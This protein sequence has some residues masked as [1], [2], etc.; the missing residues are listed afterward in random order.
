[1]LTFDIIIYIL[2]PILFICGF[3]LKLKFKLSWSYILFFSIMLVYIAFVSGYTLFPVMWDYDIGCLS[4]AGA[5]NVLQNI[6]INPFEVLDFLPRQIY[7]NVLL[8]IPF[9]FGVNFLTKANLNRTMIYGLG[10]TLCI[11]TTQ[12]LISLLLGFS[13]RV[14]DVVDVI[15]NLTGV[16]CGYMLFRAFCAVF[17]KL[18]DHFHLKGQMTEYIAGCCRVTESE[19]GSA[20]VVNGMYVSIYGIVIVITIVFLYISGGFVTFSDDWIIEINEIDEDYF[21]EITN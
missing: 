20:V 1:M 21:I 13:Y 4:C 18:K 8:T 14:S 3:L 16:F 6:N 17:L 15:L 19:N 2:P 5:A 7:L 12:L 11:E 9:G 10:F